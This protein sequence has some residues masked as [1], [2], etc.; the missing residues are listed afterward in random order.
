M[1]VSGGWTHEQTGQF[2]EL[3]ISKLVIGHR[4]P[5]ILRGPAAPWLQS[6]SDIFLIA[7]AIKS[8][9]PLCNCTRY[10]YYLP[11]FRFLLS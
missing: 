1:M 2:K 4:K 8:L 5:L 11:Y 3:D 7:I 6:I 9:E 10:A